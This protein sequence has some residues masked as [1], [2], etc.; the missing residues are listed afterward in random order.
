MQKQEFFTFLTLG[1]T[2]LLV[3]LFG[4]PMATFPDISDFGNLYHLIFNS[5]VGLSVQGTNPASIVYAY[6]SLP[7]I[8]F[9]LI[10]IM[11]IIQCLII[12]LNGLYYRCF[13]LKLLNGLLAILGL[14]LVLS[15]T[16][17]LTGTMTLTESAYTF[18][19]NNTNYALGIGPIL[20][21]IAYVSI[22]VCEISSITLE[23]VE[24]PKIK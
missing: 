6:T 8:A 2:V 16:L 10:V 12:K 9:I 13:W 14:V 5:G 17:N 18:D 23:F 3:I 24:N 4:L 11:V 21:V 19:F 22:F 15:A 1:L 20:C 7:L